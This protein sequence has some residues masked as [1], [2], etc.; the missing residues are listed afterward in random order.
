[1]ARKQINF[2]IN[3]LFSGP[4]LGER[5]RSGSPY[6]ELRLEDI[7][8]DPDQP[9]RHF[10]EAA[11]SELAESIKTH[12][13]ICPILVK[14]VEGGTFRIIA[15]ERRFRATK[16]AGLATIPAVVDQDDGEEQAILAKQLVEN[17]QRSDL[18]PTERALAIGQLKD[19]NSWSIR[20]IASNLG[21]SKGMV[22]RSLEILTL[23]DDLKLAL[24]EG[25]PESKV[26]LLAKIENRELR[27]G[28]LQKIDEL[29]RDLLET[30]ISKL[31]GGEAAE[32]ETYHGGTKSTE[33]Q[34]HTSPEDQR[35]S[36]ELQRN[37]GTRVEIARKKGNA[38]QGKIQIDFY[39]DDDLRNIFAKLIA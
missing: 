27:E 39:S 12:G 19:V 2:S 29:T 22:Q 28:L 15:G 13:V 21:I 25:K 14:P 33:K 31:T 8:V 35:I 30:E 17:L 7:D 26:L 6:R 23:P 10:D 38:Q 4:S 37:L 24:D 3:P 5:N 36:E 32:V 11:L 20:E 34:R 16:M 1:M 18:T 9:R